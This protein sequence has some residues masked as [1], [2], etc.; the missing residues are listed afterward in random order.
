M[1]GDVR[2]TLLLRAESRRTVSFGSFNAAFSSN[3]T[4]DRSRQ[5]EA[6]PDG[7]VRKEVVA[8]AK[9]ARRKKADPVAVASDR[10]SRA[11]VDAATDITEHDI[12]RRAYD[13]YL[14]RGGEPGHEMEDW[15]QAE[16][17]LRSRSGASTE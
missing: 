1:F 3:H 5:E 10:A 17:E 12:A 8:M 16:R 4:D 6:A 7:T 13:L 14:T 9:S 2:K 11:R 15:L